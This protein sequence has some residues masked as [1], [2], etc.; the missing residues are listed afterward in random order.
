VR[1][2]LVSLLLGLLPLPALAAEGERS[3]SLGLDYNWWTVGQEQP[4]DEPDELSGHGPQLAV[5][6][7]RAH[8][9]TLWWR[10]SAVGGYYFVPDGKAWGAGGTLGFTYAVDVLRYVPFFQL[11]VGG[12]YLS[13]DG[14]DAG[15]KT[16][17][18]LGLG[19]EVIQSR[20]HSFTVVG[21]VD[22]FASTAVFLSLGAR[23]SWRWG[24][25]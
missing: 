16:V 3:L 18:E 23:Y 12:L 11:G 20:S 15:F 2:L 14:V 5:D 22:T 9:D 7:H 8:E 13:G 4:G 6:Y 21:K 24:Y 10:A 17:V 1:T 19:L 25:F